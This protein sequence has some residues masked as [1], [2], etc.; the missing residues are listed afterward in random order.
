MTSRHL[1][2]AA[3]VLF[4]PLLVLHAQQSSADTL[5][6]GALTTSALQRDP[7]GR[8]LEL[9]SAQSKLRQKTL[10]AETRPTVSV[11]SMAQYQSDVARIPITLP[12]GVSPP[13]PPHDTYDARIAAQ[14]RLYDP[15]LAP[16]RAVE[17]AQL[18]ESQARLRVS[19]F[20]LR[21]NVNDVFF[22]SLRA[23]E[24][25]AELQTTI[26][27]LD[28]QARVAETRVREGAALPSEELALRAELLR[29]RQTVAEFAATRRASLEVLA[30]LTGLS[31]DSVSVLGAPDMAAEVA[32]A[33]T[34]LTDMRVRA[35]YE[36]FARSRDV[37]VRQEQARSAQDRPRV[38]AFGRV[39][40][41]RPG[42]NP[43]NDKFDGYWL[44]GVQLQWTPWNWGTTSRDRELLA[45][46]R[47]IVSAEEQN[48]TDNL[49]RGVAQDL[50]SID[51][52]A[53]T[54]A[55]DDEIVALR[56]RIAAETRVRFAEGVVTS[57]EYVDRETDVLSARISRTTHRVE[58]AQVRV[59]FLTTLGIE[60][61]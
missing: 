10:D 37:L 44:A 40:Y 23:Q 46:Q 28:A 27:D 18:A 5:R 29:R 59:R 21:Q 53:S 19:L 9:L 34:S 17:D 11:E 20:G 47:Q 55:A 41:G 2:G 49:R 39:G 15:A 4:A 13:T 12:G 25:I 3:S 14:Q 42:L 6:L 22:A 61:R 1:V 50:A 51:R 43:L 45:L 33:R 56:E 8:E 60:V 57:A 16:R 35:E 32:R 48:F 54:L 30:D 7:R 58:L 38:S 24:Q 31:L 36:Q 52:L 26:T